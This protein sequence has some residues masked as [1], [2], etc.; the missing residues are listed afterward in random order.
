MFES[1]LGF[2]VALA[3]FFFRP[4]FFFPFLASHLLSFFSFLLSFPPPKKKHK[5]HR[6]YGDLSKM[7]KTDSIV[8]VSLNNGVIQTGDKWRRGQGYA[9][10]DAEDW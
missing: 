10:T 3:V 7:P 8:A 9:P 6:A 4:F 1:S 5:T 2:V